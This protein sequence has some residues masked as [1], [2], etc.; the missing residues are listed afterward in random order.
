METSFALLAAITAVFV[1]PQSF[2]TVFNAFDFAKC[3]LSQL[4]V[5]KVEEVATAI[6][7]ARR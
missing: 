5:S 2:A 4:S 1:T 7:R 3:F 6:Q